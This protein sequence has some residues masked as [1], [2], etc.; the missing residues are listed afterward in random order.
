MTSSARRDATLSQGEATVNT[1]RWCHLAT[2]TLAALTQLIVVSARQ[3]IS[4]DALRRFP[5]P[6][7]A[8]SHALARWDLN[9]PGRLTLWSPRREWW[10]GVYSEK[11]GSAGTIRP[12]IPCETWSSGAPGP[13]RAPHLTRGIVRST[14]RLS[15]GNARPAGRDAGARRPLLSEYLFLLPCERLGDPGSKPGSGSSSLRPAAR[16]D[17]ERALQCQGGPGRL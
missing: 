3:L 13:R 17:R 1:T 2:L 15:A 12:F 16:T 4:A 8:R 11:F 6:R 9:R 7:Q 10:P 14:R 5:V